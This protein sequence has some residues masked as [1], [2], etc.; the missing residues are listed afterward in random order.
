[1]ETCT[2]CTM[3]PLPL[4]QFWNDNYEQFIQIISAANVGHLLYYDDSWDLISL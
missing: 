4:L 1:M 3:C 2:L